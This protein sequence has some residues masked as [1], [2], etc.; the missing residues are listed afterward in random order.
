[1]IP[2]PSAVPAPENSRSNPSMA[3]R[4]QARQYQSYLAAVRSLDGGLT[5]LR[6][7]RK[8]GA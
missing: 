5:R 4:A 7:S 2:T 6:N 3:R 8:T 1:M